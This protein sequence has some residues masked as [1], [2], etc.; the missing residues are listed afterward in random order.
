VDR[1][2]KLI[3]SAVDV[4]R[5][6]PGAPDHPFVA[7][8]G[9]R[10]AVVFRSDQDGQIRFALLGSDLA[11]IGDTI[12]LVPATGQGDYPRAARLGDGWAVAWHGEPPSTRTIWGVRVS[13]SGER[14]GLAR[15][16][17]ETT[18]HARYPF[19]LS[20]GDRVLMVYSNDHDN[21][22]GYELFFRI[23]DSSPHGDLASSAAH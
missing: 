5:G 11:R 6:L 15:P 8:S 10:A 20:L 16:L 2:A 22:D 1:D 13:A 14:I 17:I 9:D 23:F 4:T 7:A 19:L 12:T 21:T 3:G 18:G